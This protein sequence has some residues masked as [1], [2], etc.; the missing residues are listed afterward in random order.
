MKYE[1]LYLNSKFD[2]KT[3]IVEVSSVEEVKKSSI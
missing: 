3:I 2:E 1:V